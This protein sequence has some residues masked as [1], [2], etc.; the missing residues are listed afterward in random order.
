M[1]SVQTV[2]FPLVRR[3]QPPARAARAGGRLRRFCCRAFFTVA[4][5]GASSLLAY[6]V[7]LARDSG[8]GVAALLPLR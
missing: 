6:E 8:A 4:M 3:S 7:K 1:A 5:L 2:P